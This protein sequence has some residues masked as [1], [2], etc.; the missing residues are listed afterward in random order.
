MRKPRLKRKRQP[1]PL[2]QLY[3]LYAIDSVRYNALRLVLCDANTP[4]DFAPHCE[5][6][7]LDSALMAWEEGRLPVE[8]L[9]QEI[10][11]AECC[12]GDPLILDQSF[13][14]FVRELALR[15]H[16]T[17]SALTL[18][19]LIAGNR[20]LE[21]WLRTERGFT[22]ILTPEE[23]A[24]LS[25]SLFPLVSRGHLG[26]RKGRKRRRGGLLG[27][28]Q[29]FGR[30][31]LAASPSDDEVLVLLDDFLRDVTRKGEGLAVIT[32]TP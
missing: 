5:T 16:S 7:E 20:H 9:R 29:A 4:D 19:E 3:L 2:P 30:G 8:S 22:G 13:P 11:R 18:S 31:I 32:S 6:D 21:P 28:L 25:A 27:V 12:V 10:V 24:I 17:E 23:A 1:K 14:R 15:P 26:S